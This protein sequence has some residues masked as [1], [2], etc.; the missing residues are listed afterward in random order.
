[1]ALTATLHQFRVQLADVDRGVY[2]ALDLRMARHPSES[3][4]YLLLRLLG[5]CLNYDEALQFSKGGLSNTEEPALAMR[6]PDGTWQTWMEVGAPSVERL[7]RAT[8][9][10][11]R[12]I[13]VTATELPI[14]VQAVKAGQIFS[15][16][17]V[18][19]QRFDTA[20]LDPLEERLE[21]VWSLELTRSDG[22][23][24]LSLAGQHWE[25]EVRTRLLPEL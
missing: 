11:K 3:G 5:Y 1:M 9:A 13:I 7:H 6:D 4:R 24:Y 15:P 25:T 21:R 19:V 20:F 17:R 10:C 23:I 8:K 14:L 12:V 18:Q 16:D 22:R 2:E